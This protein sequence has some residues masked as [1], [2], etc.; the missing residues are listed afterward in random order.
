MEIESERDGM[1]DTLE[2]QIFSWQTWDEPAF[3]IFSFEGVELKVP[4]GRFP[5]GT[6]FPGAIFNTHNSTVAFFPDLEHTD[7]NYTFSVVCS[8]GAEL[9]NSNSTQ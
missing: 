8:V 3:G 4:V 1:G 7:A 2:R 6:K 5:I 9:I